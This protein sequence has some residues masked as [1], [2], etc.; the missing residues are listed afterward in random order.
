MIHIVP[1]PT[2]TPDDNSTAMVEREIRALGGACRFLN[3]DSIDP[4]ETDL[5]NELIWACGLKQDEH[6]FEV[7]QALSISNTVVNSPL[8]IF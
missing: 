8:S 6:Q 4:F 5:S 7:L 3:L 2:D 1:K